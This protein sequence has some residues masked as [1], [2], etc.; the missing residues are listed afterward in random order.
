MQSLSK[1]LSFPA[2][3]VA[4]LLLSAPACAVDTYTVSGAALQ[5]NTV[6]KTWRGANAMH[7]FGGDSSDMNAWN[8]DIVREF[9]GDLKNTPITGGAIN[10]N[11]TWLHSLEELITRNRANDKVTVI[12]PFGWDGVVFS[13]LNPSQQSFYT[14]YKARMRDWANYIKTQP[15]VWIEV[16]NEPYRWDNIGYPADHSLWLA[17]MSDMV[18]NIRATGC[19]NIILVPGNLQGQGEDAI[20]AK[21][22]ALLKNRSNI[23]FDLHAYE[24]WLQGTTFATI[25]TRLNAIKAK[26]VAVLFGEIGP[27]NAGSLMNPTA[28]LKAARRQ[29]LTTLAWLWKWDGADQDALLDGAGGANNTNNN[30]WGSLYQNFTFALRSF[31]A[32]TGANPAYAGDNDVTTLWTTGIKQASGQSFTLGLGLLR[33]WSHLRLDMGSAPLDYPRAY[34]VLVSNDGITWTQKAIGTGM[35][36]VTDIWP[37][38]QQSRWVRITLAAPPTGTSNPWSMA[39]ITVE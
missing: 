8:V 30:N 5:Q 25:E 23:V 2:W 19:K 3:L 21:G 1:T 28:F 39:E 13:G 9:I 18:D 33:N 7:V 11:G 35:A 34:K 14:A 32:S 20:L 31:A 16:W 12:A 29:N 4:S 24:R 37:G 15:D 26:N 38:P 36:Y 17:D 22:A 27:M 6:A 10:V